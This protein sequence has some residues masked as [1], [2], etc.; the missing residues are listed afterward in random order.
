MMPWQVACTVGTCVV[1]EIVTRRCA[2]RPQMID[3]HKSAKPPST[4]GTSRRNSESGATTVSGA[5]NA[6]ASTVNKSF[7]AL[8]RSNDSTR[9]E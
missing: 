6:L 7:R 8:W 4:D 2:R 3:S 1:H 9:S 5:Y